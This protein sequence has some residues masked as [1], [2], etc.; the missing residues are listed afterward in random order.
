MDFALSPDEEALREAA[1]KFCQGRLPME[2]VRACE[3]ARGG[4]DHAVWGELA[5]FGVFSLR[6]QGAGVVE[7]ALVFEELGRALVPGPLVA[8]HL[9][10]TFGLVSGDGAA[11]VGGA[12]EEGAGAVLVVEHLDALDDLILVSDRS[13]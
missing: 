6:A 12:Q 7:A 5:E 4:V 3:Q 8:S 9:A 1:R 11:V 10:A 2:R 13:V